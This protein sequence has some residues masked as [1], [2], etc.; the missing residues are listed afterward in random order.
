[1]KISGA[2]SYLEIY[3]DCYWVLPVGKH[4]LLGFITDYSRTIE[5]IT[6]EKEPDISKNNN[7]KSLSEG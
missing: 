7:Y 5:N 6:G 3:R 1:M 4:G 2:S